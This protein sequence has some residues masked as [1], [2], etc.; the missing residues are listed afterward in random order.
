MIE[1]PDD[2][3]AAEWQVLRELAETGADVTEAMDALLDRR[4]AEEE[5]FVAPLAPGTV[6]EVIMPDPPRR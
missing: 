2:P 3:D 6:C 4:A 1:R 5:A